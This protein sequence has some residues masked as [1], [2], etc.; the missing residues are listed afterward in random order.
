MF[1]GEGLG[2][3]GLQLGI[4]AVVQFLLKFR[5]GGIDGLDK[6]PQL[7]INIGRFADGSRAFPQ[8]HHIHRLPFQRLGMCHHYF[9]LLFN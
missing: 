3:D 6:S 9:S 7:E 1:G 2:Q 4:G 5:S 8:Q